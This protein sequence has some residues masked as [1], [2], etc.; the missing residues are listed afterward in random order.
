M[1]RY[2][3]DPERSAARSIERARS[4]ADAVAYRREVMAMFATR[5]T[6]YPTTCLSGGLVDLGDRVRVCTKN[7]NS[8]VVMVKPAEDRV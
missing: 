7:L 6:S 3:L 2:Y 5:P 8:D 1:V 4:R